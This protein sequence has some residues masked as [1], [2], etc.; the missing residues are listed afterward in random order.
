MQE[1]Q[2]MP[3]TALPLDPAAQARA[4]LHHLLEAG[5]IIGRDAAGRAV[6]QLA[7]DDWLLERLLTFDAGSQDLEDG[8]DAEDDGPAVLS[9]D[10]ARPKVIRRRRALA[11]AFGGAD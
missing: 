8:D 6:I 10:R 11:L 9:F 4:L 3:V 1:A 7:A 5:D 2:P